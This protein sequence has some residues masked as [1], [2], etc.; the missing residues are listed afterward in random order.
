MTTTTI[1]KPHNPFTGTVYSGKN[2]DALY[3]AS[4]CREW[5]TFLQWNQAGFKVME[6]EH[7]T[8]IFYFTE[9]IRKNKKTGKMETVGGA[10]TYTVFNRNQ[11][12]EVKKEETN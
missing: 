5:A 8:T 6:G 2:F 12:E 3:V 1:E 11:V 9:D 10:R 4:P 7:G